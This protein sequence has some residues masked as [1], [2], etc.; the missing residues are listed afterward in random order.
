M[1]VISYNYLDASPP[2]LHA[3]SAPPMA[4]LFTLPDPPASA[5]RWPLLRNLRRTDGASRTSYSTTVPQA[6]RPHMLDSLRGT[7]WEAYRHLF[8]PHAI[9]AQTDSGCIV[10]S[11][12]MADD[13]HARNPHA[14][15]VMIR[16][17]Q[18]LIET[19]MAAGPE[20]CRR[21]AAQLE[22]Q[23]R[24]GMV[25]YDPYAAFKVRIVVLG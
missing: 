19:A 1:S 18:D 20:A 22:P 9:A 2:R 21:M 10:V 23:L 24:A 14:A 4:N 11:W 16:L 15:P 25:G 12:S 8:P 5:S 6:R 13:P 17:E 7:F 3:L